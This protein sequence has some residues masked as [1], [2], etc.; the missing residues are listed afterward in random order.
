MARA[1]V[2]RGLTD[3]REGPRKRSNRRAKPASPQ[4]IRNVAAQLFAARGYHNTSMQDIASKVG[5]L[6]G[7]LYHHIRSK[8]AI[9]DSLVF[10]AIRDLLVRTQD[11]AASGLSPRERFEQMIRH[12]V[13]NMAEHQEGTAIYVT[14]RLRL[15]APLRRKYRELVRKHR[16]LLEATGSELLAAT[17]AT[18]PPTDLRLAIMAILGFINITAL[19][20]QPKGRLRLSEIED[21]YVACSLRILG[22]TNQSPARYVRI[23]TGSAP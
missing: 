18:N 15:S 3:H 11:L 4:K 2:R 19:W 5:I 10:T 6:K 1:D 14:E 23:A 12:M 7:S 22:V 21:Q 17:G 9:L 8:Q 13:R 16:D 20:Y